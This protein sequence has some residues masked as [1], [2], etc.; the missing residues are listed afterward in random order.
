M[1][2]FPELYEIKHF[3]LGERLLTESRVVSHYL[4]QILLPN[5]TSMSIFH[6]DFKISISL[7]SIQLVTLTT[8]WSNEE[9]LYTHWL[10]NHE[11]SRLTFFTYVQYY[12]DN[13]MLPVVNSLLES[14]SKYKLYS[15][16]VDF[17]LLKY[18]IQCVLKENTTET[19]RHLKSIAKEQTSYKTNSLSNYNTLI[20]NVV[21]D[22]C[23][24]SNVN[25]LHKIL[26]IIKNTAPLKTNSQWL[27]NSH[28][29]H[30]YIYL[31]SNEPEK[32][33]KLALQSQK[34]KASAE[35]L[36]KI[37]EINMLLSKQDDVLF[38]KQKAVK[39]NKKHRNTDLENF[40]K[41]LPIHK[42]R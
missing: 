22:S 28:L 21:N 19:I 16:D 25:E 26:S 40:L 27:A 35:A 38:W 5:F 12:I 13:N 39:F 1:C 4:L 9:S 30:S 6:D 23:K 20:G 41:N 32:A 3:S 8:K 7:L 42:I 37:I 31:H 24:P 17:Y 33:L 18:T 10:T 14:A 36:I 15:D 34:T 29:Y 11:E 2:H